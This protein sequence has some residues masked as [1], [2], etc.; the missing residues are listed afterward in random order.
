MN[1]F[2]DVEKGISDAASFVDNAIVEIEKVV[3][4]T[5]LAAMA[6]GLANVLNLVRTD[7]AA[8]QI[9]VNGVQQSLVMTETVYNQVVA[10]LQEAKKL[11]AGSVTIEGMV[12]WAATQA[13]PLILDVAPAIVKLAPAT[14]AAILPLL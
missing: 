11:M 12:N 14:L 5:P 8:V 9:V 7:V 13:I 1:I 6:P 10:W 4:G 2:D 3:A